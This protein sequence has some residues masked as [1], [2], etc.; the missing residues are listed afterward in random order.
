M[1]K[2][3]ADRIIIGIAVTA[4]ALTALSLRFISSATAGTT[5][6]VP[7][8]NLQALTPYLSPVADSTLLA[9]SSGGTIVVARDPFAT[10]TAP[11][12]SGPPATTPIAPR[13]T[14]EPG[15]SW[16]VSS[17][18]LEGTRRSAIVNNAWVNV[19]DALGSG[20]RLTAIER[21]HIIVTDAKGIRH[22][23]SI[24]GGES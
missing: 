18:S 8:T 10:A 1:S 12:R 9:E 24:Q 11:I 2:P 6:P 16:V 3:P 5:Q 22:K 15:E 14:A 20:S 23:V 21:D 19:G 7:E 13:P 4:L 17:I